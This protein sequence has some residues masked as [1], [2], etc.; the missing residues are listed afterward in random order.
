MTIITKLAPRLSILAA[1]LAP[2]SAAA[3]TNPAS[4]FCAEMG[5]KTVIA[6]LASGDKL[7]LCYLTKDKIVEEW[8]LF[9]MFNG[10]KPSNY[11]N[12][13]LSN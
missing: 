11:E 8:T 12:P 1:A 2:M 4:A 7:G 3:E 9:R 10:E 6:T 5:G 13:F